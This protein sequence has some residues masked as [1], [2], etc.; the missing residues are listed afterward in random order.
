MPSVIRKCLC[1]VFFGSK[2]VVGVAGGVVK[3]AVG[4]SVRLDSREYDRGPDLGGVER[5]SFIFYFTP[6]SPQFRGIQC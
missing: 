6:F 1:D 3:R 4:L 5:F 2:K